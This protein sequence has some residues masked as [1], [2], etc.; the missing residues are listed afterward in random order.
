MTS[1]SPLTVEQ[2]KAEAALLDEAE[3]TATQIRQTT[4]VY[5]HMTIDEAYGVQAA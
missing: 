5:P 4:S 3:A 1:P 2:I